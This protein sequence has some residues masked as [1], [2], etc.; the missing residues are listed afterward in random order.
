MVVSDAMKKKNPAAVELGR[1]G[2]LARKKALNALERK[3]IATVAS[4]AAAEKRSK[5]KKAQ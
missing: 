5:R 1:R 4:R 2:G 3:E